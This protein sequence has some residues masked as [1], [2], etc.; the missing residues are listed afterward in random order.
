MQYTWTNLFID[1][2]L[3]VKSFRFYESSSLM[4]IAYAGWV[5]RVDTR[6]FIDPTSASLTRVDRVIFLLSRTLAVSLQQNV[7]NFTCARVMPLVRSFPRVVLLTKVR[8]KLR[9]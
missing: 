7:A 5:G 9:I 4:N 8:I 2:L 3:N 1:S 6:T